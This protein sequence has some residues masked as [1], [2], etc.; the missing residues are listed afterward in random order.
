MRTNSLFV[1][2]ALGMSVL[3]ATAHAAVWRVDKD[4]TAGPWDG[5]SWP[6]AIQTIQEGVDVA[7][8]DGGGQRRR[9]AFLW[10]T[11][12]RLRKQE[13]AARSSSPPTTMSLMSSRPTKTWT[14]TGYASEGA[15]GCPERTPW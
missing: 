8:N 2:V 15:A 10:R 11:L 12:L 4:N 9:I 14:S 13:R 3:C 7:F 1:V 6:T 5:T